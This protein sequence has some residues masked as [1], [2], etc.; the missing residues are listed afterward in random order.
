MNVTTLRLPWTEFESLA[1][2]K[3]SPEAIKLLREVQLSKNMLLLRAIIDDARENHP[4]AFAAARM[5]ANYDL[6]ASVQQA[7]SGAVAAVL[8]H[9]QVGSWLGRCLCRV[10]SKTGEEIPPLRNMLGQL[11]AVAAA[12]AI[13]A[14]YECEVT[15]PLEHGRMMLPTLGVAHLVQETSQETVIVRCRRD[16]VTI[17]GSTG[18]VTLPADP[19]A[20]ADGWT[21]LR[22]LQ[23][24]IDGQ[25]LTVDLDDLSP[26]RDFGERPS[27]RLPDEVVGHWQQLLED[28]WTLLVRRHP[29]HATMT[30]AMLASIGT[31][32]DTD[33]GGSVNLTSRDAFGAVYM[34]PPA[35]AEA[36]A[37]TLVHELFHSKLNALMELVPLCTAQPGELFYS[38]WREDPRPLT[39]VLHGAYSFLAVA[40]FWRRQRDLVGGQE[41]YFAVCRFARMRAE[42]SHALETL[43]N[44]ERLTDHGIRF[45]AGMAAWL[46]S[47]ED[48]PV[49]QEPA[50]LA[51]QEMID[52]GLRWRL[53]NARPDHR[54]IQDIVTAWL[55]DEPSPLPFDAVVAEVLPGKRK[56]HE[57]QRGRSCLTHI[58]LK[59][60]DRFSRIIEG[61]AP[62]PT[63]ATD[64]DLAFI[65]GDHVE[66]VRRY[67]RQVAAHPERTE[68]WAGLGM[69]CRRL[70]DDSVGQMLTTRP[71]VASAVYRQIEA[72]SETWPAPLD[73]ARWL[74]LP[75][76]PP[77]RPNL[78]NY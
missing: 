68:Q 19:R 7:D 11:G 38:P 18:K 66:A 33:T 71:E 5:E 70:A 61:T 15:V 13:H 12:A 28:A 75:A 58:R 23:A 56:Q 10:L 32:D 64:A 29:H 44:S 34:S 78:R 43:L 35:D 73:V 26:F 1:A 3:A 41:T 9:P 24:G 48:V 8:V 45:V 65:A 36:L 63:E 42:V 2:G 47:W 50:E 49:P 67:S 55:R 6:L 62:L 72:A 4:L 39:G 60:P 16:E 52:H 25:D 54:Q 17:C 53:S 59:D 20:D 57:G 14:G 37:E 51:D 27:D 46:A 77:R 40:D 74:T 76:A 22:R 69:A 30:A 31:L 21:G